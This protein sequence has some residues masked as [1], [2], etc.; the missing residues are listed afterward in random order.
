MEWTRP[1]WSLGSRGSIA[2]MDGLSTTTE[3]GR[4]PGL[5]SD[6]PD[7]TPFSIIPSKD[8]IWACQRRRRAG[9]VKGTVGQE[10]KQTLL[11]EPQAV[12]E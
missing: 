12:E 1:L 3:E 9:D 7:R 4:L 2:L 6:V 11:V 8:T 5:K 10:V